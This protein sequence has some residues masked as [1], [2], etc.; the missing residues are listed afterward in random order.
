MINSVLI[1]GEI[2]LKRDLLE[3]TS[4]GIFCSKG[5]FY[6]DP[7]KPVDC[8]LITH[9]HGDHAYWGH[10]LY[11]AQSS[12]IPLIKYRVGQPHTEYKS[13]EYGEIF[14]IKD[15]KVSFHPAGHI[16]GSS[17]IR[18]EYK[19]EV[20]VASGDY[21]L[22]NDGLCTPFEP[23]KC[24]AFI[25]ESTFGLPCFQWDPQQEIYNEI[26]EWWAAN[27]S[28]GLISVL[29]GY[30]LGKAQR[31]LNGLN[32]SIG[33]IFAHGAVW[34]ITEIIR[35]LSITLPPMTKVTAS[36]P[37]EDFVGSIV[38]APPSAAGS[39]WLNRFN[40]FRIGYASGWMNLKGIRRR[41]GADRGFVLSDHADWPSLQ[42]AIKQTGAER[43][44]VT[45]GFTSTFA[46]WLTEQGYEASEAYTVYGGEEEDQKEDIE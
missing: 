25:T 32:P 34:N 15:V 36:V 28:Q 2:I 8:A 37:K 11:V 31:L 17:Q 41:K 3:F 9:A 43:I 4:K 6:I 18:V 44:I 42:Q 30:S 40:P 20:W 10:R 26:N 19:G 24:H 29:L 46:R 33:P 27:R 7:W 16:I 5:Q 1:V 38:I 35:E 23:V 39:L 12:T 13:V 45:H 22:E 14:T 21:K